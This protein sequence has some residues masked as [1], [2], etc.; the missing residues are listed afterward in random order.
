MVKMMAQSFSGFQPHEL[1]IFDRDDSRAQNQE[2]LSAATLKAFR[3]AFSPGAGSE[4]LQVSMLNH[5][6]TLLNELDGEVTHSLD[7]YAWVK[8]N[9]TQATMR[10]VYGPGNPF[11]DQKVE[12]AFWQVAN[13]CSCSSLR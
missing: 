5:L 11:A 12:D 2:G 13:G 1:A 10:A 4:E 3:A 7:L 6:Q 8:H 9:I